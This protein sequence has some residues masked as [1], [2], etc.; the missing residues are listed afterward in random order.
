MAK[1]SIC[2]DESGGEI[3]EGVGDESGVV[4]SNE[5]KSIGGEGEDIAKS[6]DSCWSTVLILSRAETSFARERAFLAAR[7]ASEA[8]FWSSEA[9]FV[10]VRWPVVSS[11]SFE[12]PERGD[13]RVDFEPGDR[14]AAIASNASSSRFLAS[15]SASRN[16]SNN[17]LRLASS[18]SLH[19]E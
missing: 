13:S 18:R 6:E 16:F 7:R 17:A 2:S 10:D 15:L 11:S 5:S 4:S 8:I 9:D 12:S 3:L 14:I 1:P 19:V